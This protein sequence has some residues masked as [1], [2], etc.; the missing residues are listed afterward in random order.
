VPALFYGRDAVS[1]VSEG[2]VYLPISTFCCAMDIIPNIA[3][4]D[5]ALY[6]KK[7]NALVIGDVHVGYES[8][9]NSRGIMLPRFHFRDVMATL[10]RIFKQ[11]KKENLAYIII[12]GDFKHEFGIISNQE[13][14]DALKLIDVLA[15]RCSR[16]ILIKG[17]HDPALGP[18]AKKRNLDIVDDFSL[19]GIFICHGHY[20]PKKEEFKR[21]E[22]VIIGNE[23]PA[24]SIQD[25]SRKETFKCFL[26]GTFKKKQMIAMPSMNPITIGTD[27]LREKFISPF[28]KQDIGNFEVFVAADKT[29]YFGK[30]RDLQP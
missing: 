7:H 13:W 24:V 30:V 14:R 1:G 8:A 20:I 23:H 12:N 6:L 22:T 19:D 2:N 9:L 3:A 16:V 25:G 11:L 17:N 15:A 10:E 18:I 5:V 29:Y 28:L 21:A 4:I 26:K 27:I